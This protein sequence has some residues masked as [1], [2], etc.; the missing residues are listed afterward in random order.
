[1][2]TLQPGTTLQEGKY[3]IER[4]LG[5]GSFG[6]TYLATAR[7][8]VSGS[9]GEMETAVKVALK[10]FFME[11]IN[12]RADRLN[13]EGSQSHIFVNYRRKFR[14][15]A[16]NLSHV[17]HPNIVGVLDVFDENNTTYY[18]MQYV[19]G[20]N[21]DDYIALKGR[22]GVPETLR[23]LSGV[24]AA[25]EFIHSKRMLH[26]DLKPK[27]IMWG[28][29]GKVYLIDF[30]LS[31]QFADN[32]EPES[33]T[34]LGLGTPG[35]A[36]LEQAQQR[37]DGTFPA[38]L[39]VYSLGA[40]M[41]K[42]LTGIRPPQASDIFNDGFP[43]QVM[44]NAKVNPDIV[45]IVKKAMAP[46][47]KQRFQSVKEMREVLEAVGLK[48]AAVPVR[49]P[50]G[51]PQ[52][53]TAGVR[54]DDEEGTV[55][56]TKPKKPVRTSGTDR[57]APG[58][59]KTTPTGLSAARP[60]AARRSNKGLLAALAAG[61]AA[62]SAAVVVAAVFVFKGADESAS[63]PEQVTSSVKMETDGTEGAV[64]AAPV[65]AGPDEGTAADDA[66]LPKE[67][68]ARQPETVKPKKPVAKET[69]PNAA[70][71]SAAPTPDLPE[72]RHVETQKEK[73]A[74]EQPKVLRKSNDWGVRTEKSSDGGKI[75]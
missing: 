14:R 74:S 63:E 44:M 32:G 23:L 46:S 71:K 52:T 7:M 26:L 36:P 58:R 25:L 20:R 60:Y 47:R 19:E 42:M 9:L 45:N 48:V 51:K 22:L 49:Q 61:A 27:N 37:N 5:T 11:E 75:N 50:A 53:G 34:S 16:E 30:G 24:V 29:D 21:L 57:S 3:R 54:E 43:E 38:T 35:Y 41:Y 62:L 59:K 15:E 65:E 28:T 4:V 72:K 10:E 64:T 8:T 69:K 40:T 12:T 66:S 39:D 17:K 2:Q 33:S 18:A 70:K 68:A 67:P 1:M 31:K 6:V 73:S 13:V 56:E 55:I